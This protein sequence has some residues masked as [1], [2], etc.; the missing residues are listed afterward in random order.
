MQP[1]SEM[2]NEVY[3]KSELDGSNPEVDRSSDFHDDAGGVDAGDMYRMGKEQQFK[4]CDMPADG[5]AD[6]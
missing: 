2:G 5:D 6:A 3:T 1:I 4:V